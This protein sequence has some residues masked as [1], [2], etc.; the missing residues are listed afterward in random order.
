L[1]RDPTA[2]I[3]VGE[4]GSKKGGDGPRFTQEFGHRGR[5]RL[6]GSPGTPRR[7]KKKRCSPWELRRTFIET[8]KRRGKRGFFLGNH[9]QG[10]KAL[11]R[12]ENPSKPLPWWGGP[13]K[14]CR[15]GRPW[16]PPADLR[17]GSLFEDT[18]G[19][20]LRGGLRREWER[21]G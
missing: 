20:G 18:G 19:G 6:Q 8:L 7:E 5:L 9:K 10:K 1:L 3:S 15:A 17:K 13:S 14:I 16:G 2:Q 11:R 4:N 12:R 21:G